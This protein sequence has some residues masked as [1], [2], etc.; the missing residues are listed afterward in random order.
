VAEV[1]AAP[2]AAN[3]DRWSETDTTPERIEAALRELLRA[4][5]ASNETLVPARVLNLAV[6]VDRDWKGEIAN[7][8]DRVGRYHASRTILCAVEDGRRTIDATAVMSSEES[9]SGGLG[10]LRESVELDIG[11]AHLERMDTVIAPI[12][13]AELPTVLWSPH[14]HDGAVQTLLDLVD[15]VLLDS[16]DVAEFDGPA[17]GLRRAAEVCEKVYVVDL[18]WLRTTPWRERLAAAFDQPSRRDLL[19]ELDRVVIRHHPSS[20][21]SAL[22]LVGWLASRLGWDPEAMA[23]KSGSLRAA[24]SASGDREVSV[25]L[26]PVD[27][28]VPGI[29]GVTVGMDESIALSLDRG[30]GGLTA[31]EECEDGTTREWQV[32][33]ASRGEGGILGEGVRQALLRDPTYAPALDAGRG[34]SS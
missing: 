29:A 22:L 16:D 20:L 19:G 33:G 1:V 12:I 28:A 30:A 23:E 27:Q 11:P 24:A 9:T 8:L 25:Q 5:H 15:V 4:R 18:A 10:V 32:L 3:Q 14:G 7:R 34:F 31:R 26:E 17:A 21:A 6:I 2:D 13:A